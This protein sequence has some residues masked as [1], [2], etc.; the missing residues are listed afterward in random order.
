MCKAMDSGIFGQSKI[1][2]SAFNQFLTPSGYGDENLF[3]YI[4]NKF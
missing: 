1:E 4:V 2:V 3:I